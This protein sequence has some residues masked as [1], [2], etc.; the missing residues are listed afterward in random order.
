[1]AGNIGNDPFF[2][3][4]SWGFDWFDEASL[5][6]DL[7]RADT[8]EFFDT[9]KRFYDHVGAEKMSG[10]RTGYGTWTAS[11]NSGFPAGA[12]A[13]IITGSWSPGWLAISAP[14]NNYEF[15]WMPVPNSRKGTKAQTLGGHTM[16]L[17]NTSDHPEEAFDFERYVTCN[18]EAADTLFETNGFQPGRISWWNNLDPGDF[19]DYDGLGFFKA[20]LSGE[21]D[22]MW[23]TEANPA[24]EQAKESFTTVREAVI[25]GDI[26][27]EEAASRMQEELTTALAELL[28]T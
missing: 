11:P 7:D 2:W 9:I 28:E 18:D 16:L 12:Q 22:E 21:A 19:P 17:F 20:S 15:T 27:S 10:F 4:I 8:V 24:T 5:T 23:G 6:Y 25:F 26:T 1:M 13:M 3:P 14:E